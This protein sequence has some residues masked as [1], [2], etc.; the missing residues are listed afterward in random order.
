[1]MPIV[2]YVDE[3]RLPTF[4]IWKRINGI[5]QMEKDI[6]FRPYFYVPENEAKLLN[7]I[8]S[9]DSK[10][11]TSLFGDKVRRVYTSL[12]QEVPDAKIFFTKNY[13]ADVRFNIRYW[14][15]K[16]ADNIY[17]LS[18]YKYIFMDIETDDRL[19][20]PNFYEPVQAILSIAIYNSYTKEKILFLLENGKEFNITLLKDY[21]LKSFKNEVE[22]L[23]NFIEYI[24][25]E[26]FDVIMGWNIVGF[27]IPYIVARALKIGTN[28]LKLS[29]IEKVYIDRNDEVVIKGRVIM[30]MMYCFT[31][32]QGKSSK[33]D[34]LDD[35]GNEFL[36]SGKTHHLGGKMW[37]TYQNKMDM[38][39]EYAINDVE[40]MIALDKKLEITNYFESISDLGF[41]MEV[42]LKNEEK[43][44]LTDILLLRYAKK[45]NI[46]LP[47]KKENLIDATYEG[48]KVFEPLKGV[49]SNVAVF[50]VQR[51]YPSIIKSF[52]MSPECL[53]NVGENYHS[54]DVELIID[55]DL[56]TEK[57]IKENI[58]IDKSRVGIIPSLFDYLIKLR[59]FYQG[60]MKKHPYGSDE[61][62]NF[63]NKQFNMKTLTNQIYG[64]LA[65]KGCRLYCIELASATTAVGRKILLSIKK[66]VESIGLTVIAG[67]T[68]SVIVNGFKTRE[69]YK[70]ANEEA[71][72]YLNENLKKEFPE[73]DGDIKLEF[74]KVYSK[75]MFIGKKKKYFGALKWEE[76]T[77]ETKNCGE[78]YYC[79]TYGVCY[80]IFEIKGFEAIRSNTPNFVEDFQ[81]ELMYM[82]L[83]SD[84]EKTDKFI[85]D[86]IKEITLE[87]YTLED[88]AIPVGIGKNLNSYKGNSP[89]IR[90]AK[91]SN[92]N[93]N[94]EFFTGDKVYMLWIKTYIGKED[95]F[96]EYTGNRVLCFKSGY[97]LEIDRIKIDWQKLY[98]QIHSVSEKLYDAVGWYYKSLEPGNLSD[99]L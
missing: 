86:F 39:V 4:Y 58:K 94:I 85:Y 77:G 31:K 97:W 25:I 37:E 72:K 18:K 14:I 52:N 87:N 64:Q 99:Y 78:C 21:K 24:N 95:T 48:A 8:V 35:I 22:L 45:N 96:K 62:K 3:N 28:I 2:E 50:D 92:K 98:Q 83:F 41:P 11:Y 79:K 23:T 51:M 70:K 43:T 57:T 46:I 73:F 15:D 71:N 34:K 19:G 53:V 32:M 20:L 80:D 36:G 6:F 7:K 76:K 9:I 91:W 90:G 30:D 44:Q 27:D 82:I 75:I 49:F 40:I 10:I 42:V 74:A 67:D 63:D 59:K 33:Y 65:T 54:I 60:E 55:K 93:L 17:N 47:S 29:P 89:H 88:L 68:D 38:F 26:D 56:P 16:I 69:E 81:I 84:K 5:R 13:E 66:H 1:M 61:Y 12:P